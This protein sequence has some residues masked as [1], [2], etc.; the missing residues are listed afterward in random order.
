MLA[1]RRHVAHHRLDAVDADRRQRA[2]A[3]GRPAIRSRASGRAPQ[4]RMVEELRRPNSCAPRRCRAASSRAMTSVA[5]QR[6]RTPTRSRRAAPRGA[7]RAARWWRT[8]RRRRAR[9]AEHVGAEARPLARVLDRRERS[10]AVAGAERPVRRDRRVVRAAPR[11]RRRRRSRCSRPAA[12]IHSPSASNSETSIVVPAPVVAAREQRG[13]DAGVGVHAGGDV[14]DRDADL[15]GASA[16]PVIESR[17]TSLCT[18]RS[19][20]FFCAYGPDE[21]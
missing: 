5:G 18:S 6:A 13:Q 16:V 7:A 10:S 4:L 21:P 8:A 3:A 9:A 19:Y 14:G 12:P 11:R 1:E 17:P 20:A 2:R 15:A